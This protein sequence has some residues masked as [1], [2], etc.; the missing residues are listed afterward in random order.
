[1]RTRCPTHI[2][3]PTL[4]HD[5]QKPIIHIKCTV[6]WLKTIACGNIFIFFFSVSSHSLSLSEYA[7][8]RLREELVAARLTGLA[9]PLGAAAT[10]VESRIIGKH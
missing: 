4:I 3:I 8:N 9:A 6:Q 5:K 10:P 1:V 2:I 7:P